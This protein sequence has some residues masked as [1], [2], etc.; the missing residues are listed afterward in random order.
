[1]KDKSTEGNNPCRRVNTVICDFVV[2]EPNLD[3]SV[4][5]TAYINFCGIS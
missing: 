2:S 4:L 3:A 5:V 1:M